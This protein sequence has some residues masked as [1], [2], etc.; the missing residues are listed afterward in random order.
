MS[1]QILLKRASGSDPSASD[2]TVGEIAIRTD[3]GKLFTK[4]DNGTVA[5][6][7]GA[8]GGN[9]FFINTISSSSG[10]GGG[11]ASFNGSAYRFE[12]SNPPSQSAQQ[13]LVS[14]NGVIQKPTSGTGQPSQGFAIDG[15]D[16]I[17]SDAPATGSD[18]FIVTYAS[19]ALAEP[20]DN[21]V[22]SAK[23]VDG[24]IVNADINASAAIARTKLANV[25]VVDDTSP[26]LGGDLQS[27][28]NDIDF[29]NN[30][31]ATFGN[32]SDLQI[33]YDGNSRI[34]DSGN[35]YLNLISNGSGIYLNKS[36]GESLA[37]FITD[38]SVELFENGV[39]KFE[40]TTSGISVAG[41]ITVTGTVDGVDIATRDTL[42][43][44][45]T[46]SSGVLTNGVTATTQSASDNSTKVATTAYTDTAIANLVD[47]SPSALNTLN[48]LAAAL[49]DDAN[50]STTVT[51][52]I[53]TK[54]PLSGGVLT[55]SV[56]LQD[57]LELQIGTGVDLKIYHDGTSDR[58]DS[59]GTYLI[60][61]ANNHI[62]RNPSGNEDYA[63]FLGNGAVELY[64]NNTKRFETNNTG[65]F[66]TGELGC[67]TLYMGD[68]EKAKFGNNDDLQIYHSGSVS[69]VD[70]LTS[71]SDGVTLRGKNIRLQTNAH[72]GA[73]SALNAL[74]NG[75]VELFYDNSKKFE[76]ASYGAKVTG[77]LAA[78][79]SITGADDVKVKLGDSDDLQIFHDSSNG[80]SHINESGSGSLVIKA[81]NTYINSS[82][83]EAMIAAIA[84]GSVELYHNNN[85]K[86]E[87]TSLGA[88]I[89]GSLG[90]G[91]NNPAEFLQIYQYRSYNNDA[92]MYICLGTNDDAV[93]N[94]AV[95]KW[96][97]GLTGGAYGFNYIWETLAHTQSSYVERMRLHKDGRLGIGTNSIISS[98]NRLTVKNDTASK[99]AHFHHN[100]NSQRSCLDLT[101]AH[102]T[103]NQSAIMI[104][105][106]RNDGNSVGGIFASTSNVQYNTASDYRLKENNTAITDGLN[107]L[108]L[109]KPYKFNFKENKDKIVDGFF[110]HEVS[111]VVPEAITGTKDEV[112]ENNEPVY[113]GIDQSK[114]IPLL[115]AAVQELAAKVKILEDK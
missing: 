71:G 75:A 88:S 35:G 24:S 79:T 82:A 3:N 25:D 34:F 77:R 6:I 103:G 95:Y 53:A 13:L 26:Q 89:T 2:L 97:H 81:T 12:L 30:D 57:N 18:F 99:V 106:R 105:F 108:N 4:K 33:Y 46:S 44:G 90:I 60:I 54:L 112:N 115:V 16:I 63:K 20:S 94:N 72:V 83:D 109:L 23:I 47:S 56:R 102:A 80:N 69:F 73:E 10:T 9:N 100:H 59:A 111:S 1:N 65:A 64:Y 110:A 104:E 107:R 92:D 11:S 42:F 14:I 41:N 76:T 68:N 55:G 96:R 36:D 113:Q 39:K 70:D 98:E 27:N 101:N 78:T 8:G 38:G 48:E 49:G 17:L 50:F 22:T 74:A 31:K 84:D 93:N 86:L 40:T 61:E 7:S 29:A 62:F 85:K 87:T 51:N 114:L 21:T 37:S 45:L 15:N 32:S 19:L 43:G 58:I 52:S 28:G 91:T 67:D 5:E 66:C